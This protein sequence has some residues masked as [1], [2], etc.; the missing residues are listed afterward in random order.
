MKT[1]DFITEHNAFIAQDAGE[2]HTD[3]EVQMARADCYHAAD[4][5]IKLHKILAQA[6]E[7]GELEGWVS[8]KITLANDY[9]RTVYEYLSYED[10]EVDLHAMPTF[11]LESAERQLA[12]ELGEGYSM[13]D[14]QRDADANARK[15]IDRMTQPEPK[16]SFA[17]Q[18]G[19]KIIGGVTG[20]VKGAY[21]GFTGQVNEVNPQNFDSDED[22]Y[23]AVNAPAKQ[24][25]APSSY[26]HS[27]Q[28]DDAYFREIFRKKRE[29][30][31]KAQQDGEQGVAEGLPKAQDG[32]Y[33]PDGSKKKQW[34]QDPHW[35][36]F[37][38]DRE[39]DPKNI[40]G[41][42]GKKKVKEGQLNEYLVRAGMPVKDVLALNLFQDFD[43]AEGAAAQFPEFAQEPMWKQ[44][45]RKYAPIANML[46]KRLLAQK[47]QLTDAE[48]EAVDETWYDGSDAYDDVEIEYLIDIYNQQIDTLEALLAGNLTD[49]E[50]LEQGVA[51]GKQTVSEM[52]AGGTGAG[53]FATGPAGGTGKPGTGVPKRVKNVA[54]RLTPKIGTGIYK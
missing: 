29:A 20:A 35:Q 25:S 39:N 17:T 44:V 22:Y 3:H 37:A 45:V 50:F 11:A 27:Q 53:G 8:E 26:P 18:V 51:E 48:A 34:H 47:R 16:K 14:V 33:N 31:A 32:R 2:M 15:S 49:E 40:Y 13:A 54:K 36:Q 19:N 43:P 46:E 52:T 41:G 38:K 4:Y 9:L 21:K 42:V 30:A 5:A 23:N 28:D 12:A 10:K 6:G 24:R 1:T 7:G